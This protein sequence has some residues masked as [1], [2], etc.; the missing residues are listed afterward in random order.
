MSISSVHHCLSVCPFSF[1]NCIV[2][3]SANNGFWLSLLASSNFSSKKHTNTFNKHRDTTSI[4]FLLISDTKLKKSEYNSNY[5]TNPFLFFFFSFFFKESRYLLAVFRYFKLEASLCVLKV[6][7][8]LVEVFWHQ[9]KVFYWTNPPMNPGFTSGAW[10]AYPSGADE[11]TYV[12]KGWCR[13]IFSFLRSVL[14]IFVCSLWIFIV[15][16][17]HLRLTA[18]DYSFGIFNF[19]LLR[20]CVFV[21]VCVQWCLIFCPIKW[22]YVLSSVLRCTSAM[23]SA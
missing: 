17:V 22:L 19:F 6:S 9:S 16:S 15:L 14:W 23:I 7:W 5:P 12:L 13:S 11:L 2:C 20:Y 3:L 21:Y 8:C 10:T 18:S 1:R 4:Y